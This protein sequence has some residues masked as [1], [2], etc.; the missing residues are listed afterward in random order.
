[1]TAILTITMNPSIDVSAA[2]E[3]VAPVRKL[4]CTAVRRDAGGG[5]INVAR[6]ISRLGNECRALYPAGGSPGR[7]LQRLLDQEG[8]TSI[9]VNIEPD[10][11][12]SFTILEESSSDQ[13]RFVLPGPELDQAAGQACLDRLASLRDPPGYV[14][15]SGSLPPGAPDDFYAQVARRAA[16]I[17]AR[18]VLDTS[19]AALAKALDEGI[20]LVK[21][22]LRE[23]RDLTGRS[24]E[25]EAEWEDAAARLVSSG[26]AEAVALTLGD[27]G[28]LLV[29]EDC[30]LRAPAIPVE[31]AS[32]VG[33]GDS[34]VAAMV[35]RLSAGGD[36]QDAFR[37]GVAAGTAALLT[38]GTELCRKDDV[39]RLYSQVRLR[40]AGALRP[41]DI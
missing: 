31:V 22:N 7:L 15:V 23:L 21:P 5:G 26:K 29:S 16:S 36:L 6:V 3:R 27:R 11:R 35:W 40:R 18:V 13:Y 19:G 9:A 12:E 37:Y 20:Y 28:A 32:A 24:L 39:E 2:T 17:G 1:M 41:D 8:I 10:T 30:R 33:A 34:F 25:G 14:V 4:R 38:P